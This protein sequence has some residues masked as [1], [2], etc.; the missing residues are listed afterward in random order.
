MLAENGNA[1]VGPQ[2]LQNMALKESTNKYNQNQTEIQARVETFNNED[3]SKHTESQRNGAIQIA[4]NELEQADSDREYHVPKLSPRSPKNQMIIDENGKY[5]KANWHNK[6]TR[7]DIQS[8]KRVYLVGKY[9]EYRNMV[10]VKQI[11]THNGVPDLNMSSKRRKTMSMS[12]APPTQHLSLNKPNVRGAQVNE[13]IKEIIFNLEKYDKKTVRERNKREFNKTMINP[14]TSKYGRNETKRSMFTETNRSTNPCVVGGQSI[15]GTG[16]NQKTFLP[17]LA[18]QKLLDKF[19]D[20]STADVFNRYPMGQSHGGHHMRNQANSV[21][22]TNH[23]PVKMAKSTV[24]FGE[25]KQQMMRS[26]MSQDQK[27]MIQIKYQQGSSQGP[28]DPGMMKKDQNS[29]NFNDSFMNQAPDLTLSLPQMGPSFNFYKFKG[30]QDQLKT[31]FRET[32]ND[33]K[34][35][36][37]VLIHK[38]GEQTSGDRFNFTKFKSNKEHHEDQP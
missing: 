21:V 37:N 38:W 4:S 25:Q 32:T 30:A 9:K 22:Y 5:E 8:P 27:H 23:D 20:L 3:H 35:V 11:Q 16:N 1:E 14:N 12:A 31:K 15:S 7:S 10:G 28:Y 17:R 34:W 33:V 2:V 36:D 26:Q 18:N 6:A 13:A 24:Y 19:I 29:E